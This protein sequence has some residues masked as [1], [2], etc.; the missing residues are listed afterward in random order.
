MKIRE[1]KRL[2]FVV[3]CSIEA[4]S[5]ISCSNDVRTRSLNMRMHS[6]SGNL[7]QI[8]NGAFAP[9]YFCS[10]QRCQPSI[11]LLRSARP[12]SMTSMSLGFKLQNSKISSQESLMACK[13]TCAI[14]G[15]N[16][17]S[18]TALMFKARSKGARNTS[19]TAVCPITDITRALSSV[20]NDT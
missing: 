20:E 6:N 1:T 13:P 11:G 12:I 16:R 19:T 10:L 8:R 9:E 17:L 7:L 2:S 4:K 3:S 5:N 14:G 18:S 15:P